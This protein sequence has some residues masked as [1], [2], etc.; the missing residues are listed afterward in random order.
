[1]SVPSRKPWPLRW[2]VLTIL[3]VIVPYTYV[4]LKFRKPNKAFEPYADMKN[5]ANVN[6]LLDA[7]YRRVS[8]PAE[9]PAPGES[10]EAPTGPAAALVP[11]PG[12]LPAPLGETLVELPRLPAGY[13][14]V[15]APAEIAAGASAALRFTVVPGTDAARVGG[16]ELFLRDG[17]VVIVPVFTGPSGPAAAGGQVVQL[18]L[19]PSLL[20][21]G[22]HVFTLAGANDSARWTVL[23]R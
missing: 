1:M 22:T 5:Q 18:T 7:G 12:G 17:A 10:T 3:V 16:A 19:P 23:V 21:P 8:L 13:R 9:A 4:N 14:D 2:I 20:A 6:R 15:V 11:A